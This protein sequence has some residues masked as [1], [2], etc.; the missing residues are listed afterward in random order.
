[1][2]GNRT[3]FNVGESPPESRSG[4]SE[5]EDSDENKSPLNVKD[6][7]R[8]DNRGENEHGNEKVTTAT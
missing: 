1:M 6:R 4:S 8:K 2:R 7:G 3:S 5:D